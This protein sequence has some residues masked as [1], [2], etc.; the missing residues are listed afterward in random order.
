[1]QDP[2]VTDLIPAYALG[3]LEPE[4]V[5]IVERHLEHCD[6]CRAEARLAARVGDALLVAAPQRSA[7]PQVRER[8]LARVREMRSAT[9]EGAEATT[10]AAEPA[11]EATSATVYVAPRSTNPLARALRAAFGERPD[12]SETDRILRDLLL[13]PESEVYPVGGTAEAPSASARLIANP[14]RNAAVL[15]A[16]GLRAPGAGRAY[17]IWLLRDGKPIPNA[18]FE[19]DRHGRGVSL[20]HMSGRLRSFDTVAVTPEPTSGSPSPTGPIM[21]AGALRSA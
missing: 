16:N 15:L 19:I 3:A 13:D 7:P 4:E 6:A 11:A 12:E 2:H 14:Q 9:L 8:L 18:L 21:L 17:Q 5:D 20:V 1:M 10:P